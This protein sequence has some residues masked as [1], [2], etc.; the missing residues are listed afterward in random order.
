M[1]LKNHVLHLGGLLDTIY[2]K[3]PHVVSISLGRS[4]LVMRKLQVP[5]YHPISSNRDVPID[6]ALWNL[7]VTTNPSK[8]NE[9]TVRRGLSS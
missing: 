1:P 4:N 7:E 6:L 9:R 3:A 5:G 2:A 8:R